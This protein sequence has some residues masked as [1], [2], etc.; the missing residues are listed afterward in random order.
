MATLGIAIRTALS[1]CAVAADAAHQ[2]DLNFERWFHGDPMVTKNPA[3]R[4]GDRAP[5]A[6]LE[7][8]ADLNDAVWGNH[9]WKSLLEECATAEIIETGSRDHT[10][11]MSDVFYWLAITDQKKFRQELRDIMLATTQR[12]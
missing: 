3:S 6:G 10:P 12:R 8:T 7:W 4:Y 9:N 2:T 11:G 5:G 1:S